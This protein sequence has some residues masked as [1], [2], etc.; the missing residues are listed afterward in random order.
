MTKPAG[1][2]I[3][4]PAGRRVALPDSGARTSPIMPEKT[5]A[6]SAFIMLARGRWLCA[7]S[8]PLIS[9]SFLDDRTLN[10][11]PKECRFAD[12]SRSKL[13]PFHMTSILTL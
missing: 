2:V 8:R 11:K 3:P 4:V 9:M 6:A 13:H 5:K 1:Q 10:L 7:P 12:S